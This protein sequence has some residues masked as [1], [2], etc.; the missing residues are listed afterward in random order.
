M[1]KKYYCAEMDGTFICRLFHDKIAF[2]K[3][4]KNFFKA[5]IYE[6]KDIPYSKFFGFIA[7]HYFESIRL[8][9]NHYNRIDKTMID[10]YQDNPMKYAFIYKNNIQEQG[11]NANIN[12]FQIAKGSGYGSKPSELRLMFNKQVLLIFSF[13]NDIKYSEY[14]DYL[15]SNNKISINEF[16]K[17]SN[18]DIKKSII[19]DLNA[20]QFDFDESNFY[21]QYIDFC[22]SPLGKD[23]QQN[24][25]SNN[26]MRY[27]FNSKKP[28]SSILVEGLSCSVLS[29]SIDRES[30]LEEIKFLNTED[31]LKE[32]V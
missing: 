29:D 15:W 13:D 10:F 30:L 6:Y 27:M 2:K 5:S 26:K 24:L 32:K 17:T 31:I 14:F 4:G 9:E 12:D 7:H 8:T 20:I 1:V 3:N 21:Y 25:L 16:Y 18:K 11:I 22:R 19:Y 28:H 23:G